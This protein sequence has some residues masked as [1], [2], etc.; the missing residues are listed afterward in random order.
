M[1]LAVK[2]RKLR[3][4]RKWSQLEVASE[5]NISQSAYNKWES[6]QSKPT[7]HNLNKLSAIFGISLL[8]LIQ[9]RISNSDLS[10]LAL[11]ESFNLQLQKT[12][13]L[14]S[15]VISINDNQ[16][17]IVKLIENQSRLI[18]ELLKKDY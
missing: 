12:D 17:Q 11:K 14:Q 8:D 18:E 2:L 15:L 10:S 9:A 13:S 4:E 1:I 6:G 16:L 7:L 3:E 5:L